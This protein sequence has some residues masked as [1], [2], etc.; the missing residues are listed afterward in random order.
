V[1]L[2]CLIVDDNPDFL[3]AARALLQQEGVQVVGVAST[4]AEALRRAAELRPDVT[5]VDI[6]LGS[7]SGFDLVRCLIEA[8]GN[9][10][11]RLILVS[12]HA[13]EDFADLIEASPAIGFLGKAA[14]SA[15]AITNLLDTVGDGTGQPGASAGR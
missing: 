3:R 11:G 12:T 4:S 14:L 7:D 1:G 2:R 10:P 9:G 5:L 6:N 13:Q 8:L 15:Q